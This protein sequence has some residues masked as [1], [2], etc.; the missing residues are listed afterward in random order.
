MHAVTWRALRLLP[1]NAV[2][3]SCRTIGGR[4]YR[5]PI[6]AFHRSAI[7]YASPQD[8]SDTK[9]PA[10]RQNGEEKPAEEEADEGRNNPE[11][12][13]NDGL[14]EPTPEQ[15]QRG[16]DKNSTYGSAARRSMRN[17]KSSQPPP[18]LPPVVLPEWFF[19]RR[20]KL[21][22]N[23]ESGAEGSPSLG[24]FKGTEGDAP[25]FDPLKDG[26]P[27]EQDQFRY[28]LPE[29]IWNEVKATVR[30]GLKL[31]TTRFTD[32]FTPDKRNLLLQCP[33]DGGIYFLDEVVASVAKALKC[34]VVQLDSQDLAEFGGDYL[35]ESSIRSLSYDTYQGV[36]T[37][38]GKEAEEEEDDDDDFAGED[39][40]EE[41]IPS[42]SNSS[43]LG[44]PSISKVSAIPIGTFAG[45]LEDLF[46][47]AKV[48]KLGDGAGSNGALEDSALGFGRGRG[49]PLENW[50]ELKFSAFLEALVDSPRQK[51]AKSG[52]EVQTSEERGTIVL[53]KDFKEIQETARGARMIHKIQ[54][55][56]VKR[57]NLGQKVIMLGT[58]AAQE[59]MPSFTKWGIRAAQTQGE[60]GDNHGR[61]IVVPPSG[62][63]AKADVFHQDEVQRTREIN[64]RHLRDMI[65]RLSSDADLTNEICDQIDVRI[66]TAEGASIGIEDSVWS[67]DRVHR[68]AVTVL[69]L[70]EDG[71]VL[72]PGLIDRAL[73]LLNRSDNSKFRMAAE[74]KEV[75][76][77]E[78]LMEESVTGTPN[79]RPSKGLELEERMKRLRKTC[80]SHE[81]K[82]L[83]GVVKPENIHTAFSDVRAPSE[84][85][86]ALRTLTS[87][88]LI[89]PEAFT[90]GVL[91]T[92]KIPGLLL[93]GPP[94][95][96]KTLLAKAVAKESGATVLEVSGSEVYDMYVGEGEKNVK[97][98]FSLARKLSPCI[99]FIDEADAIFGSRGGHSS[100]TSHRELINQFLREWD[101]MNN[102]SAFI[103]VATNRPFDLDDA[104]LRRLPRRLL[105]DLPV[106]AD[107]EAIL[108]IHLKDE[109]L[110]PSVSL[111][112]LASQ[113]PF[114]SGSDL[115]NLS[116]A[117][118]LACVREEN[119]A[120]AK[121]EG[122]EPYKY[123]EKRT[124][125]QRHFDRA[126]EEISASINEDMSSLTAI[127]KF[128]EKYGDR[129]SQRKK[130]PTWGFATAPEEVRDTK[131][132]RS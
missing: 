73:E 35:T 101:G 69:G 24:V 37:Q 8:P 84:T 17:R 31:P 129:R 117:A 67:F 60:M 85:V 59:F 44:N 131:P 52:C 53:I 38:S 94:G 36:S 74:E 124:L 54:Q 63:S 3:S 1:G 30:A 119:D 5:A 64:T 92:D 43:R 71:Q 39:E 102:L 108:K 7:A 50:E 83:N 91:A 97:A 34:D 12:T 118:A 68:V 15:L 116:V 90:Y 122:P 75:S 14:P 93:Y 110:D 47:G 77:Q 21:W 107:R 106:E 86:D 49:G 130:A 127:K 2:R 62:Y 81:K 113:T 25:A 22:D 111:A 66:N 9:P 40:D 132:V 89:R 87:L 20:V 80:N 48:T 123:P 45:S 126:M 121:H 88:S 99:V 104:V 55:G 10:W 82:L 76:K 114:Y 95:T 42:R 96:G 61:T 51:R 65:R 6:R 4:R 78:K 11:V 100:R 19:E 26:T 16:Q 56:V 33:H 18:Q 72:E 28:V 109:T 27:R 128:D 98:I 13:E 23:L 125:S 103:M 70:L 58:V 41:G 79:Q 105:V 57:R 120:A 115:K 29:D 112:A 46:K 32:D